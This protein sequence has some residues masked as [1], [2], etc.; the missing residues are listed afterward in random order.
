MAD[1]ES[2]R[3]LLRRHDQ[4]HLLACLES[5]RPAESEGRDYIRTVR[6]V[7]ACYD[8]AAAGCAVTLGS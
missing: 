8:S 4:E 3:A 7:F 2:I 1:L 6:A 5:G